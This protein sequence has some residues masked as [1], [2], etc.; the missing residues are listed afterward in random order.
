MSLITEMGIESRVQLVFEANGNTITKD[1]ILRGPL[2]SRYGIG[3]MC[4]LIKH[5]GRTLNCSVGLIYVIIIDSNTGNHYKFKDIKACNVEKGNALI[6]YSNEDVKPMEKRGALRFPCGLKCY[7]RVRSYPGTLNGV[8]EDISLT[9]VGCIVNNG[10]VDFNKGDD[11]YISIPEWNQD[12]NFVGTIRRV[13]IDKV[14]NLDFI[15]VEM[16]DTNEHIV[17]LI[18]HLQKQYK[19]LLYK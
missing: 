13:S 3:I 16:K 4:D 7:L 15:G 11:I 10:N 19:P 12:T 17:H 1:T 6:I 18:S 5:N 8:V 9:G 2:D 14:D